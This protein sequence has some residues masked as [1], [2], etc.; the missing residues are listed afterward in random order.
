VQVALACCVYVLVVKF[1]VCRCSP[2]VQVAFACD[3]DQCGTVSLH[4]FYS[5]LL[6]CLHVLAAADEKGPV[7]HSCVV[8]V[9]THLI[10]NLNRSQVCDSV[11]LYCSL[12]KTLAPLISFVICSQVRISMYFCMYTACSFIKLC[13]YMCKASIDTCL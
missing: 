7:L 4:Y 9:V 1:H 5:T 13:R 8:F 10:N 6:V 11:L 3:G 2:P 12:D